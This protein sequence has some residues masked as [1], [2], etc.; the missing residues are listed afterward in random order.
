MFITNKNLALSLGS[1]SAKGLAHIGVIK[2]LLER[3]YNIQAVAGSSIGAIIASYF[4][5]NKLNVYEEFVLSLNKT[6][7]FSL[8]SINFLPNKGLMDGDKI[9]EFFMKNLGD[10][11][12]EDAHIPLYIVA[13]DL[14]T[15]K[16]V[17]FSK[18]SLFKAVRASISIPGIFS[19][20]R[21]NGQVL[22]DGGVSNPLPIDILHKK[23]YKRICAIDLNG[24]VKETVYDKI[25]NIISTLYRSFT[26]MNYFQTKYILS[27][28]KPNILL[29]PP[30]D[31]IGMLDYHLADEIINIGYEFTSK[32][33][34]Y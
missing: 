28:Y 12:I 30:L 21:I 19:P 9:C 3:G 32:I 8:F 31:H 15:G 14:E 6:K 27:E 17:V 29:S 23:G 22:V 16:P 2:F 4:A 26:I 13:T 18:G 5:F 34:K 7:V 11:N 24:K 33:L 10:V 25:P 20:F 1:G